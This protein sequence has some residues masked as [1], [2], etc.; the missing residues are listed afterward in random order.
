MTFRVIHYQYDELS[1]AEG[2]KAINIQG[3]GGS[4]S[5]PVWLLLVLQVIPANYPIHWLINPSNSLQ[6]L[7]FPYLY[8]FMSYIFLFQSG[9][10][11]LSWEQRPSLHPSMIT[12]MTF[13]LISQYENTK[14]FKICL[15]QSFMHLTA[16]ICFWFVK[17]FYRNLFAISDKSLVGVHKCPA[18]LKKQHTWCFIR[19]N[20]CSRPAKFSIVAFHVILRLK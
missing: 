7:Q 12:G 4:G 17:S 14:F 16:V 3:S 11:E 9:F 19:Y 5:Q 18:F 13:K 6:L 1:G 15:C 8:H 2:T 20:W 10:I